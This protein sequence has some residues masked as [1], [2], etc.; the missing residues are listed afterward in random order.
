MERLRRIATLS[1]VAGFAAAFILWLL[2]PLGWPA[3]LTRHL[4]PHLAL[5]G[6]VLTAAAIWRRRIKLGG[7]LGLSAAMLVWAFASAPFAPTD[8]E[9]AGETITVAVFNAHYDRAALIRFADWAQDKEVDLLMLAEAQA[10]E[11][12]ALEEIY[13]A[14]PHGLNSQT[15]VALPWMIYTTRIAVFSRTP[16]SASVTPA[17]PPVGPYDRPRLHMIAQGP[18][19]PVHVSALHPFPPILPGALPRQRLMFEET[20]ERAPADGRFI[21]LGDLNSTVWSPQFDRL[22]GRRAGDPRFLSSFPAFTRVGGVTI[23]HVLI[24]EALRVV[25]YEVGP[26][27]GSDH[28]PV[29]AVI[30]A[31]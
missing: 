26:D 5:A 25:R 3:E 28:R 23:D 15:D 1:A 31:A 29:L 7:G 18:I 17:D 10:V 16:L 13:A 11:V 12:D 9:H 24:G 22:P 30:G 19:G 14:W 2:A 20:A 4:T 6:L 21:V 27:L 8:P